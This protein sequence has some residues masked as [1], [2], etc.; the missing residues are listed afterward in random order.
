MKILEL[1]NTI[2]AKYIESILL[3]LN[4]GSHMNQFKIDGDEIV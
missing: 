3:S 2:T 4:S 1:K